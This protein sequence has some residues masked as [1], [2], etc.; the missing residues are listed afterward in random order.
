MLEWV[1]IDPNENLKTLKPMILE[2]LLLVSFCLYYSGCLW[3]LFSQTKCWYFP[4]TRHQFMQHSLRKLLPH[5]PG[6]SEWR[7]EPQTTRDALNGIQKASISETEL[8]T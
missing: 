4:L 6:A 3:A 7:W 2:A 5:G 8:K 1:V